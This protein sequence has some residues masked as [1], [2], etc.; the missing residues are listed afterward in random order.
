MLMLTHTYI[1]QN[2]LGVSGIK[3]LHS[4]IFVY[5]IVPDLLTI[6]PGVNSRQT[7]QIK[8]ILQIP[9]LYP[10]AAYIMLH[11][12]VD[13]LCHYGEI[14]SGIPDEF[15][16]DSQG[17][18]YIK[19]KPIINS[20]MDFQKKVNKEISYNEAAYRSHLI[21]E[22]IYDLAIIEQI[23]KSDTIKVLRDAMCAVIEEDRDE[24]TS[25]INWLYGL[26]KTEIRDV[27]QRSQSYLTEDKIQKTMT[28]EGRIR[29]YAFKFGIP[30]DDQLYLAGIEKIFLQARELLDDNEI[31]LRETAEAV[32]KYGWLPPVT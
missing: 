6:H 15:N 17:Y 29:L 12:L 19:G 10:K 1:L 32:K 23:K 13:D 14:C 11:L 3:N 30:I 31:F 4:D 24:F 21:V 5:N 9:P 27:M 18:C 28:I 26:D 22:M 8:R 2:I 16:P 20:I 25:T 7:H